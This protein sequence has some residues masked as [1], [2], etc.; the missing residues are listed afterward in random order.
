M[1]VLVYIAWPVKAW[2]IPQEHVGRL[3]AA[4]PDFEFVHVITPNDALEAIE[5][6]DISFSAHLTPDMVAR[7]RRV[8]W[9]H[10]SA[11]AIEG[12][13]PADA[14]R[15]RGIIVS[16][17][18]GIQAVPMAE[19]VMGGLLVLAR[20]FNQTF[21]AQLERKWIQHELCDEWPWMLFGR[22]MTIVGLGT[23]GEEIARRAHAFG[24]SVRGVRRHPD[25]AYPP[26]V[27][28][29][30]GPDQLPD[31]LRGCDVLVISAPS[32]AATR[33]LIGAEQ[34][35]ALNRGAIVV[36]V[37]RS[38]IVDQQAM[39]GALESGQ[40][41]GAVLDVFD[42]EPL[43][44]DDPLWSMPNVVITPH[45]AGF[46]ATHW[47]D[48]TELFIDN[49]RRYQKGEPLLNVVDLDAGY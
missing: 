9:V 19:Q 28:R 25:R 40:L 42:R 12:L 41:G 24:M 15:R 5:D 10:S 8:R 43:P 33:H 6:V 46:R 1:K 37:A 14:L 45:S 36:N 23:T 35:A 29:V 3:R 20:R 31:V 13:L 39:I 4:Y 47:D 27:E 38:S 16:N 7:A 44:Q 21:A 22:T 48:V 11:A 30:V 26:F 32:G 18:R 34:L 17:S 2:R 49:L